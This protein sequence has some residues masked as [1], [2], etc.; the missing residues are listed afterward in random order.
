MLVNLSNHPSKYWEKSQTDAAVGDYGEIIDI[1]F[2][3][4]DPEWDNNKVKE[5]AKEHYNKILL[6]LTNFA[7]MHNAVHLMGETVFCFILAN[8]LKKAGINCVASTT[9]RN[10]NEDNSVKTSVF[11]FVKFRNYY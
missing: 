8:M 1:D 6:T 11:E 9:R 5:L 7:G 4:I 3:Q 10:V 2:P